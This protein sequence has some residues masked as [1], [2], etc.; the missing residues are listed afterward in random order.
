MTT[1]TVAYDLAPIVNNLILPGLT[2]ILGA[3][4]LWLVY[5][6]QS[7]FHLHVLDGK[8]AVVQNAILN[9]IT[10]AESRLGSKLSVN[11]PADVASVAGYVNTTVPHALASLRVDPPALGAKIAAEIAKSGS[12]PAA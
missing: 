11:V 1:A 9:G 10:L 3:G 2:P 6:V 7:V 4:L 5:R 8:R 12:I